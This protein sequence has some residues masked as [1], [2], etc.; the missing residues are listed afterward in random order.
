M[1]FAKPGISIQI[2]QS[3]KGPL[4][5]P[6]NRGIYDILET[7]LFVTFKE[8]DKLRICRLKFVKIMEGWSPINIIII[9]T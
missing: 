9:V 4:N 1:V 5:V 3:L 6:P 7:N 2:L 8:R